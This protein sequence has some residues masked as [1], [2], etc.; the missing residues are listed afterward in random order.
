MHLGNAAQR[1]CSLSWQDGAG[2]T[3]VED[4]VAVNN[5]DDCLVFACSAEI[6]PGTFVYIAGRRSSQTRTS[7]VRLCTPNPDRGYT[8]IVELG[9]ETQDPKAAPDA[10]PENYYEFL[11][12]SPAAQAGTIHRV[13]RYLAGLYHPDNPETGDPERFLQVQRAYQVLSNPEGRAAYDAELNRARGNVSPAFAGVDFMDGVEGERNRRLAVLA[14]LYRRC[15]SNINNARVS[16]M[17]LESCMGFPREFLDFTTW[18]LRNK[19][20]IVREDN[21]DFALTVTGVDFIEENVDRL[22]VLK[23]MLNSGPL[24]DLA[25]KASQK[26]RDPEPK[27]FL[28]PTEGTDASM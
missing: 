13:F 24:W 2:M 26:A 12:I 8:I 14:V 21:S 25:E 7:R 19:K 18:Y 3:Q 9:I 20:Y 4:A 16:L 1:S 10:G 23:K 15:R 6:P 27:A 5:H 28:L 11:Q 17:E 22:P